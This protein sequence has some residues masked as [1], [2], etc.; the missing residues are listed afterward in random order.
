MAGRW[1]LR[2][3]FDIIK[4][5][6]VI[7][8]LNNNNEAGDCRNNQIKHLNIRDNAVASYLVYAA[9]LLSKCDRDE[10]PAILAPV[11]LIWLSLWNEYLELSDLLQN[12]SRLDISE[13]AG[14]SS[15]NLSSSL[16]ICFQTSFLLLDGLIPLLTLYC[17]VSDNDI[18]SRTRLIGDVE[19]V[20]PYKKIWKLLEGVLGKKV[21]TK[22]KQNCAEVYQN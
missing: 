16:D 17:R 13:Y 4:V 7:E 15:F 6:Q 11:A 19:E 12:G 9:D 20:P 22:M 2:R 10:I 3:P 1:M 8:A 14:S 5:D 21:L 18:I